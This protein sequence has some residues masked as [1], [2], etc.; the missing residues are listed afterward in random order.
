MY[1]PHAFELTDLGSQQ[2][3]IDRYPFG[4]LVTQGNGDLVATHLPFLL[5]QNDSGPG[6]LQ[7]HIAKNNKEFACMPDG[8]P[9]LA[10]FH[11]PHA[12]ISPSWYPT[13]KITQG[14]AVPT[15]NYVSV[16]VHGRLSIK[17]DPAWLLEHLEQQTTRYEHGRP[18]SWSISDAPSDYIEMMLQ[19]I[20]GIE[21]S[22]TKIVGKTKLSQNRP[23]IDQQSVIQ[24]LTDPRQPLMGSVFNQEIA[25]LMQARL[26]NDKP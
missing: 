10:M 13:K 25:S 20:V 11:G 14:K 22:I 9:V 26:D 3:I 17:T 2:Q 18:D 15:W 16:H 5:S 21:I 19:H 12:Y 8:T 1:T 4:T 24:G 6:A 23:L 7:A